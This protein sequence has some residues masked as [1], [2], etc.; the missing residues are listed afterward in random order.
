MSA[1]PPR[2]FRCS[3]SASRSG[4][5]TPCNSPI[6]PAMATG[7]GE[8][9]DA[10]LIRDVVQGIE[11]RGVLGECDG[12]L[13]GYMGGADIGAAIL[14]AVAT[15]QAR[16]S[17]GALL[18]RP[19]DRRCRPRRLRARRHSGIHARARRCRPPISSRP[20]SSSWIICPAARARPLAAARDAR[21]GGAR[22]R[23][24][25][26]P[27]DLAAHRGDAGGLHR[28]AGLGRAAAASACARRNCR[29]A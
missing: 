14:D 11:Q 18:L 23:A 4:R 28:P 7:Q 10:A 22:P 21:Q 17:G 27:G 6:T 26:H 24:A 20:T 29:S 16:Q 19:G 1:M 2:C 25:R 3:G 12:V 13:S 9:F 15:R 5:C 8:V